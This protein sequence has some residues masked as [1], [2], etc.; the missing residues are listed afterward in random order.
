M[1]RNPP[2][3]KLCSYCGRP[4]D[5]WHEEFSQSI[6]NVRKYGKLIY[7]PFNC[8]PACNKCN[9]SHQNVVTKNEYEFVVMM[10]EEKILGFIPYKMDRKALEYIK[11]KE[12]DGYL[13]IKGNNIIYLNGKSQY[14]TEKEVLCTD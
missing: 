11:Q 9:P 1:K 7:H 13:F 2:M 12:I 5:Q 4:A 8:K 3:G 14:K 6:A 10:V